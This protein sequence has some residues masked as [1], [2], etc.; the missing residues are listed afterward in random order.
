MRIGTSAAA[1]R[2]PRNTGQELK[3]LFGAGGA[4]IDL[5]SRSPGSVS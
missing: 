1:L 2:H 5:N 3:R 4:A